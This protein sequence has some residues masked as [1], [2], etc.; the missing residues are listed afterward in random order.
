MGATKTF[1][2]MTVC[3]S[4]VKG[5][6]LRNL[7]QGVKTFYDLANSDLQ[8]DDFLEIMEY[9]DQRFHRKCFSIESSIATQ[10]KRKDVIE[11]VGN[12]EA[13]MKKLSSDIVGDRTRFQKEISDIKD[14]SIET[15]IKTKDVIEIVGNIEAEMK[16]LSSDIVG[17]RTRFQNEISD[18]KESF[19]VFQ[20]ESMER[21]TTERNEYVRSNLFCK[22]QDYMKCLTGECCIDTEVTFHNLA[23]G[24]HAWQSSEYNS[25]ER[26]EIAVDGNRATHMHTKYE[27]NPWWMVD[28]ARELPVSKVVIVNRGEGHP[29]TIARLRNIVVTVSS[30]REEDGEVCGRFAGPGTAGQIIEITCAE[31]LRGRYVKLTMNSTNYLHVGEVEVYSQ[32]IIP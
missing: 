4:V 25:V 23:L 28:L 31:K 18:I 20:N 6:E 32:K 5:S 17:D 16:K 12:M 30:G 3:A 2:F 8:T 1:V 24:K 29:K 13:D 10:I 19:I 9:L 27:T 26:A 22:T 7:S 21:E 14:N 15:D 11:I